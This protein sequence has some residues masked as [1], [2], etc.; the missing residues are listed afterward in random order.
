MEE[1]WMYRQDDFVEN[2]DFSIMFSAY[3]EF[4]FLEEEI[5][6]KK[7]RSFNHMYEKKK[8]IPKDKSSN[9]IQR[10]SNKEHK[11]KKTLI[12]KKKVTF[13]EQN[14]IMH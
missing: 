10:K 14:F 8:Q 3:M 5:T 11:K 6:Q 4:K 12:N 7:A 9:E 13:K 1:C 2:T